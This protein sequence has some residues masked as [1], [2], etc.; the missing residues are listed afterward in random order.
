MK[1]TIIILL[2]S[3]T[4]TLSMAQSWDYLKKDL[5]LNKKNVTTVNDSIK[6]PI[7]STTPKRVFKGN[8]FGGDEYELQY[9]IIGYNKTFVPSPVVEEY[10]FG[11][12]C[13]KGGCVT[14]SIGA[15]LALAGGILMGTATT[16]KKVTTRVAGKS[17]TTTETSVNQPQMT[18]GEV[19]LGFGCS[20]V[21]VS[22]PLLTFG[23]HMKREANW[24]H[25][26]QR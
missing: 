25:R 5:S 14:I 3:L 9:D 12:S 6:T 21:A 23:D 19:L 1:K 17:I 22:I 18:A 8:F 4:A 15:P 10:K 26:L 2:L 7:Y 16:T 20:L 24:Q 11:V 13:Y